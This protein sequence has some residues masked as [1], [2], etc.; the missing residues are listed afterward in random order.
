MTTLLRLTA[1][2]LTLALLASPA[3]AQSKDALDLA[4]RLFERCGLAVQL[5]PLAG[6][7]EQ[8]VGQ[9]R[10]KIPDEVLAALADAG[11]I[12]YAVPAL[13]AQIVPLFARK[14][15]AEDM[16]R[17]LAWL[18]S[19]VGRRVTLA[20]ESASGHMTDE[21]LQAF[22][23]REKAKPS[24]ARRVKLL[25]DLA[26]ATN[27]AEVGA[28][29]IEAMSLGVAVGMDATQPVEKRIGVAGLRKRLR[30][31]MPPDK[32]RAEMNAS[33]PTMNAFTYR[34]IGDADL[35]AYVT[36]N[37]SPLGKRYNQAVTETLAEALTAA[38][39][40]VGELVQS[41]PEKERI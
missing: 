36:F 9:N 3:H 40:R 11:K 17:V 6:Q 39:V 35:A 4:S 41:A 7:F 18:D 28:S 34:E 29:F 21:S 10:G 23:E 38:S 12:S 20:E 26:K 31:A 2:L 27:A 22:L 25:A 1:T 37:T 32:L 24:S 30:A 13:R 19:P 5:E 16:K 15:K 8:G 14:L 33:I